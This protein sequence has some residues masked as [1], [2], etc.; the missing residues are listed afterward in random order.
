MR[1]VPPVCAVSPR[2]PVTA[3]TGP[4]CCYG[5][6]PGSQYMGACAAPKR[7]ALRMSSVEQPGSRRTRA[8]G[9][10]AHDR[11]AHVINVL[12]T[13]VSPRP[14]AAWGHVSR[15][16][17]VQGVRAGAASRWGGVRKI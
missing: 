4:I 13:T 7:P 3:R 1:T 16:A 17:F 14:P 2:A 12:A 15:A 10:L 9:C 8:R 11:L 6:R 5:R